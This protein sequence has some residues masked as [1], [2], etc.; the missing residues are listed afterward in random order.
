[1]A[2]K[3]LATTSELN[4]LEYAIQDIRGARFK[5]P[6]SLETFKRHINYDELIRP[7]LM[8]AAQD[9]SKAS[10]MLNCPKQCDWQFL[11]FYR[12]FYVYPDRRQQYNYHF[13]TDN[14][15]LK[16]RLLSLAEPLNEKALKLFSSNQIVEPQKT[17]T[18][19]DVKAH[20]I[21]ESLLPVNFKDF[22]RHILNLPDIVDKMISSK[23]Y[24]GMSR[25]D[26]AQKYY[27][28]FY[29]DP[30]MRKKYKYK[31]KPCPSKIR[32]NLLAT[33]S[34]VK[35]LKP[36]ND[37][38][39]S[40]QNNAD[41]ASLIQRIQ[42]VIPI[43]NINYE[44][45]VSF[46]TFQKY[47]NYDELIVELAVRSKN[48]TAILADK[49]MC[50]NL[51]KDFYYSFYKDGE[52]RSKYT[53]NFNRAPKNLQINL[54]AM[55]VRL[56]KVGES[57]ELAMVDPKPNTG[58][59][60]MSIPAVF[61]NTLPTQTIQSCVDEGPML[62]PE[63]V[64]K[65][66]KD[67]PDAGIATNSLNTET[68][69]SFD[70]ARKAAIKSKTKLNVVKALNLLNPNHIVEPQKRSTETEFK[71]H[72][73]PEPPL[74][75]N[76]KDFSRHILNLPDIVDKMMSSKEYSGMSRE[77]C[78]QKYYRAFYTDSKIRKKYKYK[79]KPC[80]SK[81]RNNLL[82]MASNVVQLKPLDD[83]PNSPQQN[84][85]SRIKSDHIIIS[86]ENIRKSQEDIEKAL[87]LLSPNQ[88]AEPQQT[89]TE[90]DL[91]SYSV[92]EAPLPVT[93]KDF[94]QLIMNLPDIVDKM[95]G[96]KEYS[97]MSKEECAKKY[98]KAFYT[99]SKI[100][101]KYKVKIKPCPSKI[102]RKLL[103][104][105][106]NPKQL[107]PLDV[108]PDLP[109]KDTDVASRIQSEQMV[110]SEENN[111]TS[112]PNVVNAL[113]LL[114]LN[115]IVEPQ[116]TSTEKDLNAYS[117]QEASL[118]VNYKTFSR[119]ILNLPDIVEKL[120]LKEYSGMSRE[121]CAQK[122][123]KAFYADPK[124][125]KKYKYK[126]KPCPS[127]IRN[128][129]LATASN[130]ELD[131]LDDPPDSPQNNADIAPLI[132]AEP[133]VIPIE[134][135]HYEFPV[136]FQ[137]FQKYINHD[138]MIVELAL[139]NTNSTATLADKQITINLLKDF[140]YSFYM[141]SEIRSQFKYNFNR[142]P[143]TLQTSLNAMAIR[144]DNID[145]SEGLTMVDPKPNTGNMSLSIPAV[146]TNSFP[147]QTTDNC[148][149]EGPMT[150]P[151][152]TALKSKT[153]QNVVT[154]VPTNLREYI[155]CMLKCPQKR[156]EVEK[157]FLSTFDKREELKNAEDQFFADNSVE[158]T[159]QYLL[160]NTHGRAMHIWHVLSKLS[161]EEFRAYTGIYNAQEFYENNN[162]LTLCYKH[163]IE[164]GCWPL[165]LY[166]KMETFRQLL[167]TKGIEMPLYEFEHISPKIL[168]WSELQLYT[169]FD[170]IVA[171]NYS[172]QT[173]KVIK[174][175]VGLLN[176]KEKLYSQCWLHN[177]WI[178]QV[179]KITETV[180]MVAASHVPA[181][182]PLCSPTLMKS[183][184]SLHV[185]DSAPTV[186]KAVATIACSPDLFPVDSSGETV[187][188]ETS[189]AA[190]LTSTDP[191][192]GISICP[193]TQL[194]SSR[195]VN[196]TGAE[197]TTAVHNIPNESPMPVD[198]LTAQ[199]G[200]QIKQEPIKC[201]DKLRF[202]LNNSESDDYDCERIN[203]EENII[204]ID[205]ES[206]NSGGELQCF[207][208]PKGRDCTL[209]NA[210][211]DIPD[212]TSMLVDDNESTSGEVQQNSA[213]IV[214][215]A[216]TDLLKTGELEA[217]KA[218][219]ADQR[220]ALAI[221]L[222][223]GPLFTRPA[224]ART[225][226]RKRKLA[227]DN[228]PQ[229]RHEFRPLPLNA[230]CRIETLIEGSSPAP[231]PPNEQSQQPP[232]QPTIT[233]SQVLATDNSIFDST[234]IRVAL[235]EQMDASRK[236][237]DIATDN[238]VND[239]IDQV[240]NPIPLQPSPSTVVLFRNLKSFIFVKS[241][242]LSHMSQ[243]NLNSNGLGKMYQEA[244][245]EL[246]GQRCNIYGP[247]LH[248]LFPHCTTSLLVDLKFL[249]HNLDEFHYK[250]ST[251]VVKT[252][253]LRKRVL[254][255]FMR[256]APMFVHFSLKFENEMR[257]NASCNIIEENNLV[258]RRRKPGFSLTAAIKPEIL[259]RMKEV[260]RLL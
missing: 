47:I 160:H 122:Y 209:P 59:M 203:S 10:A 162:I 90:T 41:I 38:P 37:P 243:Y 43:E 24:S 244:V 238:I 251:R 134:N 126:L 68:L 116:Q 224:L 185:V 232:L 53:Y 77:E 137:T 27:R 23:E 76:F 258:V 86:K 195:I 3:K 219:A 153:K 101:K 235:G 46:Q 40:P 196:T 240:V 11:R 201:L 75:V 44:F 184:P 208:I 173:S 4:E 69:A 109:Q 130:V 157:Y 260:N 32:N 188:R 245:I 259:E 145:E 165:N 58:N 78:A 183:E 70:Q 150:T 198:K 50:L 73:I 67:L 131:P 97:G 252:E 80:P 111:S 225:S 12:S 94:S 135:I 102:R 129:L 214:E 17:S 206:D 167:Q 213:N 55:A 39:E 36:L 113:N 192:M 189:N 207:E 124:I 233:V 118:P 136:S 25:E 221:Q 92:Q 60:P 51:L 85:A 227:L 158:H 147:T 250:Y 74:P 114:S 174:D 181:A 133:I 123:Y 49:K 93:F 177:Q 193:P 178:H 13:K 98:Y 159:I 72:S 149:D 211:V 52:I 239:E 87:N 128:N 180:M 42:I 140:Y 223:K 220:V 99:D 28:A 175:S 31:L 143:K 20:S 30:K 120:C 248:A 9:E 108:P 132:Q 148:V 66:G 56:N 200:Q 35:Q 61:T 257:E 199:C 212:H 127:K 234:Q 96:S 141:N 218:S 215:Q 242:T 7:I 231:S 151:E 190:L 230:I 107:K 216:K 91:N 152:R 16:E 115:Q 1:M 210:C 253:D 65:N 229:L 105:A 79:L 112:N 202:D 236:V 57:E 71:A 155:T 88:I 21:Q 18:E 172:Y 146:V 222:P 6:V 197:A 186:D 226:G 249:L 110:I 62:S 34:N 169:N 156:L 54:N 121:E 64:L 247:L 95:L 33:A 22:S 14:A 228:V 119:H 84:V 182:P 89:S 83:P 81:I 142:A 8:K 254:Y 29:T 100:R 205:G 103:A 48:S 217:F 19:I 63:Q 163:V 194:D 204:I 170:E 82:A 191:Q 138:E 166:V 176:E 237:I 45:P 187:V 144:L 15:M 168:H 246:S 241:L 26:C 5:F 2:S 256:T 104:I 255:K 117:I 106:S 161:L 171:S 139:R 125:R 179:P 154:F 164:N